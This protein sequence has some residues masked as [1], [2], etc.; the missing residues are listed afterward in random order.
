MKRSVPEIRRQIIH[1][2]VNRA[3]RIVFDLDEDAA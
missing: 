1:C 2:S 3:S